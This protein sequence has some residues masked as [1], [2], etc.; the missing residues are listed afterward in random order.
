MMKLLLVN[1][2]SELDEALNAEEVDIIAANKK[3]IN[4]KNIRNI[5]DSNKYMNAW[6]IH[7]LKL[8]IR[9]LLEWT[10]TSLI[11]QPKLCQ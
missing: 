9:L 6:T 10:G 7:L 2:Q 1:Y 8:R 4:A 3:L 11:I 5:D